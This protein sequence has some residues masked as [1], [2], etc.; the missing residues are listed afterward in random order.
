MEREEK[1][2]KGKEREG[3]G[4]EGKEREGK[5]R[6]YGYYSTCSKRI[7]SPHSVQQPIRL[8]APDSNYYTLVTPFGRDKGSNKKDHIHP[9]GHSRIWTML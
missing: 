3:K 4:R 8:F 5:G 2:R 7:P 9:V 6:C 1:G